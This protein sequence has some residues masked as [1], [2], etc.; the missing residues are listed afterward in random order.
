MDFQRGPLKITKAILQRNGKMTEAP[1]KTKNVYCTPLRDRR[2]ER[3]VQEKQSSSKSQDFEELLCVIRIL[4]LILFGVKS[5]SGYANDQKHF[6]R[7]VF[8]V[9]KS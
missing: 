5:G 6:H 7:I 4:N 3:D 8:A 1:L 9:W 2:P